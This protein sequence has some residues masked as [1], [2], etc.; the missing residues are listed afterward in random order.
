MHINNDLV[1]T[2]DKDPKTGRILTKTCKVLLKN[3]EGKHDLLSGISDLLVQIDSSKFLSKILINFE[4]TNNKLLDDKF[5][6]FKETLKNL[7]IPIY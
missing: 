1:I 3:E 4:K 2:F 7:G 5:N 6:K